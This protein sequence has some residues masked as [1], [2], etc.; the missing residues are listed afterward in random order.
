MTIRTPLRGSQDASK[1]PPRSAQEAPKRLQEAP[2]R[3]P[4]GSKAM[5]FE[6]LPTDFG[7]TLLWKTTIWRIGFHATLARRAP[8]LRALYIRHRACAQACKSVLGL[9]LGFGVLVCLE[10]SWFRG[11]V[12]LRGGMARAWV[13]SPK[14]SETNEKSMI[15]VLERPHRVLEQLKTI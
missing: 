15:H 8:A 3:N 4:S 11:S 9:G 7:H 6:A 14:P 12:N 10:K 2:K 5:I 13:P 1:K